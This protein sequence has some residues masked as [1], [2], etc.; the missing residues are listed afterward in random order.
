MAERCCSSEPCTKGCIEA[1]Y[2][3]TLLAKGTAAWLC[4]FGD[5][6]SSPDP[7]PAIPGKQAGCTNNPLISDICHDD[8]NVIRGHIATMQAQCA[9]KS[10][11]CSSWA[12]IAASYSP[13]GNCQLSANVSAGDTVCRCDFECLEAALNC[14]LDRCCVSPGGPGWYC[15][16][17]YWCFCSGFGP[18]CP[19]LIGCTCYEDSPYAKFCNYW[20]GTPP[21]PPTPPDYRCQD[22]PWGYEA[23]KIYYYGPY[24]TEEEC[25]TF[26]NAFT[27][28]EIRRPNQLKSV[29]IVQSRSVSS[30]LHN[31]GQVGTVQ[32]SCCGGKLKDVP[33][34]SCSTLREVTEDDC[35]RCTRHLQ[36]VK[37]LPSVGVF[38]LLVS[39]EGCDDC[40][41]VKGAITTLKPADTELVVVQ[42]NVDGD[43]RYCLD[44]D[45]GRT[46]LYAP[47]LFVNFNP[48]TKSYDRA[49][50]D[51][52]EIIE[53]LKTRGYAAS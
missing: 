6:P 25:S 2:Y 11:N 17:V 9:S 41:L 4:V 23:F 16:I 52:D 1:Y 21:A 28:R 10:P 15:N 40:K 37:K 18:N 33:L 49:L 24:A 5:P 36:R 27:S 42:F 44:N 38:D 14:I 50:D 29:P 13:K 47:S 30:C 46:D 19:D 31:C 8:V 43:V 3:N 39:A 32:K 12:D 45:I 53:Y 34:Y 20:D 26:C 48:A 22:A 35:R 51:V 7:F